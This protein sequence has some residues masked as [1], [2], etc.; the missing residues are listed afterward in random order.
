[1]NLINLYYLCINYFYVTIIVK[2]HSD[3]LRSD[4][5][6]SDVNKTKSAVRKISYSADSDRN[7]NIGKFWLL[8]VL[9]TLILMTNVF[10]KIQLY[11]NDKGNVNICRG[12]HIMVC[13]YLKIM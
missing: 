10:N 1:M 4:V 8:Y 2:C 12:I 7:E 6:Y 13:L 9:I 3:P 5:K 11:G